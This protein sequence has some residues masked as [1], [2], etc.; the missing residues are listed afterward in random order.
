MEIAFQFTEPKD[1]PI[2]FH[3]H[4]TEKDF[5]HAAR[6]EARIAWATALNLRVGLAENDAR[7]TLDHLIVME[8]SLYGRFA[9]LGVPLDMI[10]P[11]VTAFRYVQDAKVRKAN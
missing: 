4:Y 5:S 7:L 6:E 10:Q 3:K 8:Q 1:D 2:V 9:D 11:L